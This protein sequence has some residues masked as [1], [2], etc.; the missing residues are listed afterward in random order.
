MTVAVLLVVTI[1]TLRPI[2]SVHGA[3][4]VHQQ[5]DE[6][7]YTRSA[8]RLTDEITVGL[9]AHNLVQAR[10]AK[11]ELELV[12]AMY[13]PAEDYPTWPFER[14]LVVQFVGSQVISLLGAVGSAVVHA[15]LPHQ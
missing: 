13:V 9:A 8:K 12:E 1:T 3:M 14:G 4:R 10:A 2:W 15:Y 11:E 6:A 7:T 5:K